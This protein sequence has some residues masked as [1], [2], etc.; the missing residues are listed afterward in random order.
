MLWSQWLLL[1]TTC[2][3]TTVNYTKACSNINRPCQLGQ[4][5]H[6][7]AVQLAQNNNLIKNETN[8]CLTEWAEAWTLGRQGIC[9]HQIFVV[10]I[11][12]LFGPR[13]LSEL[14]IQIIV[15]CAVYR[16]RLS[17]SLKSFRSNLKSSFRYFRIGTSRLRLALRLDVTDLRLNMWQ[18][19]DLTWKIWGL[20]WDWTW[21]TWDL[22][23][24]RWQRKEGGKS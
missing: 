11:G 12:M 2:I 10:E 9:H 4:A 3:S 15:I 7:V 20:T 5:Q 17:S 16:S 23:L 19:W 22:I 13:F 14:I 24:N 1:D 8:A 6:T 18:T 21:K